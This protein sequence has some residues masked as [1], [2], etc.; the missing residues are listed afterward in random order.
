M[1]RSS[2]NLCCSMVNHPCGCGPQPSVLCCSS[3]H[4]EP[5]LLHEPRPAGSSAGRQLMPRAPLLACQAQYRGSLA[6]AVRGMPCSTCPG[7]QPVPDRS[8]VSR[9][10]LSSGSAC[11]LDWAFTIS[12]PRFLLSG[13]PWSSTPPPSPSTHRALVTPVG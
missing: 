1:D 13:Q 5:C 12:R 8:L 4:S 9:C 7:D 6:W 11:R 2:S 10:H 3:I